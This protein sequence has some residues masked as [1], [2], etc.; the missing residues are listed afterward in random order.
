MYQNRNYPLWFGSPEAVQRGQPVPLGRDQ[1]DPAPQAPPGYVPPTSSSGP[2]RAR[3][4]GIFNRWFNGPES[5]QRGQPA[6]LGA[7]ERRNPEFGRVPPFG[8]WFSQLTRRFD[9]GAAAYAF[10]GGRVFSNPLGA[11]IVATRPLPVFPGEPISVRNNVGIFWSAQMVNLGVQPT[12]APLFPPWAIAQI[13][14]RPNS[15]AAV[16]GAARVAG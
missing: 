2:P 7:V 1:R 5:R 13:L 9:R 6:P 4:R 3:V 15:A 11:G 8:L 16:A 10:Y 14:G 12:G